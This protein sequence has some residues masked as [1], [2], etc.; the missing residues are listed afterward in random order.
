MLN[1]GFSVL[2]YHTKRKR[3]KGSYKFIQID[4]ESV[5]VQLDSRHRMFG[6][7]CMKQFASPLSIDAH[8]AD[9]V[10]PGEPDAYWS[11]GLYGPA[12]MK[13]MIYTETSQLGRVIAG[14]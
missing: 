2:A 4:E 6:S 14:D 7:S 3:W 12:L 8:T 5:V 1:A 13:D 10:C 11:G 9:N